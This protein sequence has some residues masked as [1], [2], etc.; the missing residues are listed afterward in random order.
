MDGPATPAGDYRPPAPTPPKRQLSLWARWFKGRHCTISFIPEKSYNMKMGHIRLPTHDLY[1]V[2]EPGLVRR[3]LVEQWQRFPKNQALHKVLKPLIGDGMVISSGEQW[4]MQR[5]M[6]D[7]AFQEVRLRDVFPLMLE[8]VEAMR[9]RL[10]AVPDGS[11]VAVDEEMTHVTADIIFRTI[12][13]VPLEQAD[14]NRAFRAFMRYQRHAANAFI[15]GN[16][17]VPRFLSPSHHFANWSGGRLRGLLEPLVR[18]RFDDRR[19]GRAGDH[20]DILASLLAAKDPETGHVFSLYELVDQVATLFLAGHETTAATLSWS[21]YLTAMCPPFQERLH[22]EAQSTFGDRDPLFSDLKQL[23]FTRDLFRETLRL[24]PP[25]PFLARTCAHHEQMRDKE[26]KAG[27]SV[28]VAPWLIH[29]HRTHWERPDVFD[30]DRFQTTSGKQSLRHAYLP[31]SLGPR[32]CLGASFAMQEATLILAS[33]AR[34]YRFEALP[35]HVP[36]P[37][38]RLTIRSANGIKARIFRR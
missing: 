35:E 1:P 8:A 17:G 4:K 28:V 15:L 26:V 37:V 24:Y 6:I 18:R 2:C 11:T 9:G 13:S 5:R 30:P 7:P 27:S 12:F 25:L 36:Q 23:K 19:A 20:K 22:G 32:V 33:L 21:V 31:F 38:G 10:D 14:A 3:I 29:R 34:R 16:A